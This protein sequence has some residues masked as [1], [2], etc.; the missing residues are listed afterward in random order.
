MVG[1]IFGVYF[2]GKGIS[3]LYKIIRTMRQEEYWDILMETL[4]DS[5]W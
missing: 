2:N 3:C 4:K 1:A 5:A